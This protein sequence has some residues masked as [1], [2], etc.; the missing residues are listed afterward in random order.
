MYIFQSD[1]EGRKATKSYQAAGA[2]NHNTLARPH[3]FGDRLFSTNVAFNATSNQ[4][5]EVFLA[6]NRKE[7]LQ[8]QHF[9]SQNQKFLKGRLDAGT[10]SLL[11]K[12]SSSQLE[13]ILKAS[14]ISCNH[15]LSSYGT[16][17]LEGEYSNS[18]KGR[19]VGRGNEIAKHPRSKLR[20]SF[21]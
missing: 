21:L 4:E 19:W 9:F 2:Q 18:S 5:R 11:Q 10:A 3:C 7:V 13:Q 15:A 8:A 17:N 16:F 1:Y 6:R 20:E 14:P 12:T